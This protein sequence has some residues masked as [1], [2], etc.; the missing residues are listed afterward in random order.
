[1]NA[2]EEHLVA[3][4]EDLVEVAIGDMGDGHLRGGLN[5]SG[6]LVVDGVD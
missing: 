5:I 6:V 1:M 2:A 3:S 4:G